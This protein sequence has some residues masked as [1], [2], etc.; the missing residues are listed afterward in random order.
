MDFDPKKNYY[1]MLWVWEDASVDEIKK[2]FKKLAVQH[3][4]DKWWDKQKFQEANEAYQTLWDENKKAQYDSYRKWGFTWWGGG[5]GYDFGGFGWWWGSVDFSDIDLWD[6]M[7]GI[8]W[9]WFGWGSRWRRRNTS[10]EDIKIAIN[11]TFEEWYIGTSKKVAYD[12]LVRAQWVSEKTCG[13]CNGHWVV[14]QQAHTPF[15][16]M[17][18]QWA[19][20]AC[21]WTWKIFSKNGVEI[22]NGWLEK[23]RETIEVKIPTAIKNGSYI[24]FTGKWHEWLWGESW[25]LYVRI[26]IVTSKNYERK[27][28]NLYV[29][30]NVSLF[31][32]IL[33]WEVQ[34]TH[35]EGKLKVKIPKGT[36]IWDMIKVSGK[37]FGPG[38]LFSKRWDMYLITKVE[39]PKKLSKEQEKL[40]NELKNK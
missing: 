26:D 35:P 3:H 8:F 23:T 12:R 39:I 17:Q 33:W 14:T 36:Q 19:C 18:T 2:A 37:W 30:I 32:L 10:G 7:W 28:D 20:P 15:G 27:W 16:V 38:G 1:E 4:P 40:R 13:T 21:W 24:K 34:V 25:D 9:W 5:W 22:K 11:I 31:D 29:H 6:I